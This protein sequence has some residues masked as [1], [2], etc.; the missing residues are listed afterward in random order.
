MEYIA[1][2]TSEDYESIP[3]KLLVPGRALEHILIRVVQIVLF[4]QSLDVDSKFGVVR[5]A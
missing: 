2:L 3:G 5:S 4:C 1:H